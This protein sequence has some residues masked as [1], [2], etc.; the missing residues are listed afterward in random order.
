MYTILQH[1]TEPDWIANSDTP[2]PD[3]LFARDYHQWWRRW[4][5]CW[6]DNRDELAPVE[7]DNDRDRI[8]LPRGSTAKASARGYGPDR[9][10]VYSMFLAM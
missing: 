10:C 6:M 1:S 7:S 2:V 8:P 5:M 3:C 9:R 4:G